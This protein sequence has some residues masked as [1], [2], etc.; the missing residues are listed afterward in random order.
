MLFAIQGAIIIA[1][2]IIH[3]VVERARGTLT[4]YRAVLLALLWVVVLG[5]FWDV[6]GGLSHISPYHEQIAAQIGFAQSP[7]QWEVGWGDIAVGILGMLCFF[8]RNRDGWM[9]A[10]VIVLLIGYWGDLIGHITQLTLHDN[11]APDNIW[12]MPTDFLQPLVA[13]VLLI[14]VRRMQKARGIDPTAPQ[15]VREAAEVR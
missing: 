13:L 5:G 9:N 4:G 3:V 8:R 14:I 15:V 12:S 1:G 11:T 6:F 7:F 10:A 2:W